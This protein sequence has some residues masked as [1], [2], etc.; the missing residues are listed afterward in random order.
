MSSSSNIFSMYIWI[1]N[2]ILESKYI[3]LKGIEK[4]WRE[5]RPKNQFVDRT[6]FC[7]YKR[8][9]SEIFGLNIQC[10]GNNRYF[11]TNEEV[12][13][14]KNLNRYIFESISQGMMFMDGLGMKNRI[15]TEPMPSAGYF[16]QD[17][18]RAMNDNKVVTI[19]YQKFDDDLPKEHL[20]QPYFLKAYKAR[21]YLFGMKD[22]TIHTY[23][24]DRIKGMNIENDSFEMDENINA[25]EYFKYAF[26]IFV[27]EGVE[28]DD[29]L[30]EVT[31]NEAQ[32]MDTLPWH[33]SQKR[34]ESVDGKVRYQ[35]RIN[36]TNDFVSHIISRTDRVKALSPKSLIDKIKERLTVTLAIYP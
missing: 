24:L 5:R 7:R 14:N 12:M 31:E 21:W 30:I 15:F 28:P 16:L 1:I 13:Y 6:T 8:A 10:D 19:I 2:V 23:A 35:F 27:E 4:K 36:T 26:G 29:V 18:I 20:I 34:I 25:E 17:I 3:T 33:Q 9:I 11:I 32:Y 22:R